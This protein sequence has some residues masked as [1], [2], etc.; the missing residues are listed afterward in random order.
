MPE[1]RVFSTAEWGARNVNSTFPKKPAQG[2]VLHHAVFPNRPPLQGTAEREAAFGVARRIQADHMG[3]GYADTGQH[4]TIS[5]GG[6]LLEGRHGSLAAAKTGKVVRGAHA[7]ATLPNQSWFGI[8]LEGTYH[9]QF[10]MTPQ[11][12]QAMIELCA[13]LS[14]WGAF[15]S[16]QI[17][18][19]RHF[20]PTTQCPGL[21]MDHLPEFRAAVHDRKVQIQNG[22]E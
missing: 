3:R 10:L 4:F 12:R 21:V 16:Q 18:G 8:E 14:F 2:I 20:K 11:Q 9:L 22:H 7:G 17:E 6:L 19:H 1:P 13:W 5:R 15:D